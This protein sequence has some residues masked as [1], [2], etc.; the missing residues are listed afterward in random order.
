MVENGIVWDLVM[1]GRET[2][3]DGKWLENN[4]LGEAGKG[5]MRPAEKLEGNNERYF[6]EPLVFHK[7]RAAE[8]LGG[9]QMQS[10]R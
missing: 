4:D 7:R 8:D 10:T 6:K 5:E 1:E 2:D 3:N 9:I